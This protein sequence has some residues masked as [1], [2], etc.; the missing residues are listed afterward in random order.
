[1]FDYLT[2]LKKWQSGDQ[3]PLI[4]F[5]VQWAGFVLV[6]QKLAGEDDEFGFQEPPSFEA[7]QKTLLGLTEASATFK[8]Y[9]ENPMAMQIELWNPKNT[10]DKGAEQLIILLQSVT[11]E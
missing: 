9:E 6:Q 1:V 5:V 2:A 3:S 11:K 7:W 10:L 8:K 4:L